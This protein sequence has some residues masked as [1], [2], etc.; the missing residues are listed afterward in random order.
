MSFL[1]FMANLEQSASRIPN[2]WLIYLS[3]SLITTFYLTNP[4]NRIKKSLI[5]PSLI[6][7]LWKKLLFLPKKHWPFAK[8]WEHQQDLGSPGTVKYIF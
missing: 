4:E 2:A 7:L 8:K 1:R 3:Y 6:L 5:Q